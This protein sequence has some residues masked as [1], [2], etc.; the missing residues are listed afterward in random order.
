MEDLISNQWLIMETLEVVL[1]LKLTQMNQTTNLEDIESLVSNQMEVQLDGELTTLTPTLEI[2]ILNGFKPIW[3]P[4]MIKFQLKVVELIRIS[5]MNA[6]TQILMLMAICSLIH[7]VILAVFMLAMKAGAVATRLMP[8]TPCRCAA[9]AVVARTPLA[10]VREKVK[11]KE[12]EK[13]MVKEM[14]VAMAMEP[15]LVFMIC[16][17]LL[18]KLQLM[19]SLSLETL[20]LFW[21]A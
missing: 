6:E 3:T 17:W 2:I 14:A 15:Y 16:S 20:K 12:K 1:F 9:L 18:N 11:A 13:V 10:T 5:M 19:Q 8:S 7:T 21:I 4:L